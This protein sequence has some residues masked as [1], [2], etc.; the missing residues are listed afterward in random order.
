MMMMMMTIDDWNIRYRS[1]N[2]WWTAEQEL[3]Q[4]QEHHTTKPKPK[5]KTTVVELACDFL[6]QQ[7]AVF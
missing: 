7:Q 6:Q 2:F 1:A 4:Q 5:S 3:E